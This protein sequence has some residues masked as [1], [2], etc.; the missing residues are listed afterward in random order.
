VQGSI[1][2]DLACVTFDVRLH[3]SLH[4]T[5]NCDYVSTNTGIDKIVFNFTLNRLGH[6]T[7]VNIIDVVFYLLNL[8]SLVERGPGC[9]FLRIENSTSTIYVDASIW[10]LPLSIDEANYNLGFAF[11]ASELDGFHKD[12][13]G[14]YPEHSASDANVLVDQ[15]GLNHAHREDL[16]K[17]V[18]TQDDNSMV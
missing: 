1:F 2:V 16:I 15:V 12:L 10:R 13:D 5:A 17:V 3:L 7:R 6:L 14:G 18:E 9:V 4:D 8:Q 11:V